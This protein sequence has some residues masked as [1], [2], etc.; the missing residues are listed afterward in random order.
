MKVGALLHLAEKQGKVYFNWKV[1]VIVNI[2][3][4]LVCHT[5][6]Q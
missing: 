4:N 5:C 2:R 6:R 1:K 3:I